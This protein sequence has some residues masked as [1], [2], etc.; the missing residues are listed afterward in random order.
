MYEGRKPIAVIGERELVIGLRLIGLRDTFISSGKA[1][2]AELV[3]L[4]RSGKFS[5]VLAS[6]GLRPFLS[7]Q[8]RASF[9]RTL[10]PL[11]VFLPTPG[12]VEEGESVSALAK[13]VLGVS[14]ENLQVAGTKV[15]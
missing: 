12:T 5:L 2:A 10:D 1:G 3:K 9:E 15:S 6:E 4:A 13:R 14:V 8:T 11:V 7:P